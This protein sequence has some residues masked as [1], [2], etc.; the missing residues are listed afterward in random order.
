MTEFTVKTFCGR[1][2]WRK[3][4]VIGFTP[5]EVICKAVAK[6]ETKEGKYKPVN[7]KGAVKLSVWKL[8][9]KRIE[10][11]KIGS[12]IY[13][14]IAVPDG[15]GETTYQFTIRGEDAHKAEVLRALMIDHIVDGY[16]GSR[17][18]GRSLTNLEYE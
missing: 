8:G 12:I 17:C 5:Y 9:R 18:N 15:H 3:L 4:I 7:D 2:V 14:A 13:W 10:E 16:I 6:K 1:R 11:L